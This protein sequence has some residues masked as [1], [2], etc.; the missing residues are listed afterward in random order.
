MKKLPEKTIERL[1]QYRRILSSLDRNNRFYVFSHELAGMLHITAEQVRRDLMLIG[2]RSKHKKGYDIDELIEAI[3]NVIDGPE[4]QNVAIIGMGNLGKAIATY[5]IGKR[6]NL[7]IV[8]GF[9]V[10]DDKTGRLISGVRCY[11][12]NELKAIIE[13]QNITIAILTLPSEAARKTTEMLILYGIRGI[14][15][16]TTAPLNVPKEVFL[17]EF[18]ILTSLEKTAYFVDTLQHHVVT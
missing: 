16:F 5:F 6:S 1:S 11:H 2:Y 12:I 7:R 8:A 4:V 9:D 3:S 15:N 17:E 13:Q 10:S 14:L 18:D